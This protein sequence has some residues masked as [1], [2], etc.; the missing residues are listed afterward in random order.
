MVAI[1]KIGLEAEF[2]LLS[3]DGKQLVFPANYGFEHDDFPILGE[4]RADPGKTRS[5]T[6]ANFLKCWY[7]VIEK[8]KK[9]DK[10]VDISK[11]WT[12]VTPEFYT[13]IIRE[14]GTK[15]IAKCKNIYPEIDLLK[16]TDAIVENG[17][18]KAHKL[19]IGLHVHFSSS[20]TNEKFYKRKNETF[21]PV[22]IPI[23]LGG[24]TNIAEMN[25][26]QKTGENES[27]DKISVTANRITKPVLYSIVKDFDTNILTKFDLGTILKYRKAGFYEIKDYGGFE[28][29]SL[30]FNEKVLADIYNIVDYAFTKLEELDL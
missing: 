16:L 11:G 20:D 21:S 5:E 22:K 13:K 12:E 10:I 23:A 17:E 24:N 8:A 9:Q 15:S 29:R 6:I 27:E 19:S 2:F 7:E 30:P 25:L 1:N 3:K 4:F 18:I 26:Y 28:Y 14:M